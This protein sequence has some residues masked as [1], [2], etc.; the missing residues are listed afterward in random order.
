EKMPW[1]EIIGS[2]CA[3]GFLKDISNKEFVSQEVKEGFK[4]KVGN[5]NISFIIAPNL[6]W[7]D[8]IF[9]FL[10]E[11][12]ILF[13]CDV[14]GTHYCS[15]NIFNNEVENEMDYKESFKYYYDVI[16]DPFKAYVKLG[17]KKIDELL[18]EKN[19][20]LNL[21]CPSHGPIIK[22][23]FEWYKEQYLH[24]S[25]E[26]DINPNKITIAYV[27]AYG[28]TGQMSEEIKKA[29]EGENFEVSMIDLVNMPVEVAEHEIRSSYAFLIG[30]PTINGDTL[31]NIWELLLKLNQYT[32]AD[33]M[34]GAFGAFGWS[35]EATRN[36]EARLAQIKCEVYRPGLRIKFNPDEKSKLEKIFNFGQNFAK[37]ARQLQVCS[38]NSDWCQVKTGVWKCLVCG[39]IFEGEFPPETCPACGAPA[40]QFV[41]VSSEISN[42]KSEK[43]EKI[44]IL[45][46]GIGAISTIEA[47]RERNKVCEIE[48]VSEEE[49]L[50][51][52]RILLSKKLGMKN[53]IDLIK[54][55][56]WFEKN[57]IKLNLGKKVFKVITH[58][59]KILFMD[60]SFSQFDKLVI[61]TGARVNKIQ[62][63]GN[64]KNGVFYLRNKK[65][66]ER[67]N[68]FV[69]NK[70]V[71][72]ALIIGGGIL[73]VEIGTSL[74]RMGKN[75]EIIESSPR[76][77]FRQLDDDASMIFQMHLNK[78]EIITRCS[79]SI[80]E[81]YG[82]GE[83]YNEVCGAKLKH[84]GSTINCQ[85]II[86]STGIRSN[87][88]VVKDTGIH[89]NKGILVNK[90][91]KTNFEN[92]F[93]CGDVCEFE[94]K[95]N[96]LWSSAIEQGK[97]AGANVV[98]D[99]SRFYSKQEI[100]VS[101]NELGYKIFSIGDLGQNKDKKEYQILE[102]SDP[103]NE[104]YRKFYFLNNLFVGGI[105]MGSTTKA[106]Q[107]RKAID[108][109][110]NMQHFLDMHF[111]DE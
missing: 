27:S 48:M 74:K 28:Y 98:G 71:E 22:E 46:S 49:E 80:E 65:D 24:W 15:E 53:E 4:L 39:E 43:N 102:L 20:S 84:D 105:L 59:N 64:N 38:P 25:D 76:I 97:V 85:M 78:N 88:E 47:I 87:I 17:I 95:V 9:T 57:N 34:A 44:I 89:T 68:E 31:P 77:M 14:F 12:N 100:A 69:Q 66:F 101:F 41:S 83:N 51:Y 21:V 52:Y 33:K 90:Y 103:S 110:S 96:G 60:G 104:V 2:P 35:G 108:K 70:N 79:E 73:G 56:E 13:T 50:P 55:K 111:L 36:I 67:I 86:F 8:S 37:K 26:I 16:F 19:A 93:A 10:E 45:G 29:I 3:L 54:G 75:V 94:G 92:I 99:N 11:E 30:S 106:V 18:K 40:D 82:T 61:S 32:C 62:V 58:E 72:K 107:L 42:F 7:P 1:I 23:N 5:K 63:N 6:H 91:M 109:G 81:I